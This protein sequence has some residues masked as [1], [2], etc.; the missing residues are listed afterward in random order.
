M[1]EHGGREL[2]GD[3]DGGAHRDYVA[4]DFLSDHSGL[5]RVDEYKYPDMIFGS[6]RAKPQGAQSTTGIHFP[7]VGRVGSCIC[8]P[9]HLRS[10]SPCSATNRFLLL[11]ATVKLS[12]WRP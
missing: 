3:F 6:L 12:A 7:I 1:T 8:G 9:T 5:L 11:G 4:D 10:H 2:S